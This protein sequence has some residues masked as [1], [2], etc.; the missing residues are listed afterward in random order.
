MSDV[1]KEFK[2]LKSVKLLQNHKKYF[3]NVFDIFVETFEIKFKF[4]SAVKFFS[5]Y[6]W[7]APISFMNGK[8]DGKITRL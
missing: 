2:L 1:L 4:L 3:S 6:F 8:C 5:E 7:R